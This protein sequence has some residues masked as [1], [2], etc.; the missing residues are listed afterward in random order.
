MSR[1]LAEVSE[2]RRGN[3]AN[4]S[5]PCASS[6][7]ECPS[8]VQAPAS[9]SAA[10]SSGAPGAQPSTPQTQRSKV[11]EIQQLLLQVQ[12]ER[13]LGVDLC[14]PSAGEGRER[15]PRASSCPSTDRRGP[16]QKPLSP[17]RRGGPVKPITSASLA[18]GPRIQ[19]FDGRQGVA[20]SASL[21][22]LTAAVAPVR[23]SPSPPARTLA[24]SSSAPGLRRSSPSAKAD[25]VSDIFAVDQKYAAYPAGGW[26]DRTSCPRTFGGFDRRRRGGVREASSRSPSPLRNSQHA[27]TCNDRTSLPPRKLD[28]IVDNLSPLPFAPFAL[29]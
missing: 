26:D 1:L 27:G 14:F 5:S 7:A 12:R 21:S 15:A 9:P 29:S 24:R 4:L 25:F 13:E 23:S 11:S 3:V 2:E 19:H 10:E 16:T 8:L 6:S 28:E 20:R 17:G 18:R 22:R